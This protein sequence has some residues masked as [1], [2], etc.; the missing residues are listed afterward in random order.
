VEEEK[1]GRSDERTNEAQ[2][3]CSYQEEG[4][5]RGGG[6]SHSPES[7]SKRPGLSNEWGRD[8]TAQ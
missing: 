4:S 5:G 1:V 2:E 6:L 3:F 8:G 7:A